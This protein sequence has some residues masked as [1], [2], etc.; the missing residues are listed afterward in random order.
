MAELSLTSPC[1]LKQTGAIKESLLASEHFC[2]RWGSSLGTC[3]C[4]L[5]TGYH[6]DD[7]LSRMGRCSPNTTS[8][9]FAIFRQPCRSS[10]VYSKPLCQYLLQAALPMSTPSRSANVYSKLFTYIIC[11][12]SPRT[13]TLPTA[14][15][16]SPRNSFSSDS[17]LLV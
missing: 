4:Q 7:R 17:C 2:R 1:L 9:T 5:L 10:N 6:D 13:A 8:I 15:H 14:F 11:P 12:F 3:F 16:T